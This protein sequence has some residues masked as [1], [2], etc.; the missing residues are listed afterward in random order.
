M[1][2]SYPDVEPLYSSGSPACT[3]KQPPSSIL[4]FARQSAQWNKKSVQKTYS[5]LL[6]LGTVYTYRHVAE[7]MR[8]HH[9]HH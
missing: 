9:R 8:F 7:Q 4:L 2:A 3:T 5:N 1:N 6:E